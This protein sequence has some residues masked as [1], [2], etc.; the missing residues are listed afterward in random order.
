MLFFSIFANAL[1]CIFSNILYCNR[2]AIFF[3]CK[4]QVCNSFVEKCVSPA[5]ACTTPAVPSHQLLPIVQLSIA[6]VNVGDHKLFAIFLLFSDRQKNLQLKFAI[7]IPND[8]SILPKRNSIVVLM[9]LPRFQ[10]HILYLEL[11]MKIL[12]VY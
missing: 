6:D 11:V 2:N 9:Y 1:E 4:F 3:F 7:K 12:M 5:P 10:Y 8:F